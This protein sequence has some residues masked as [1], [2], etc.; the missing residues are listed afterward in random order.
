MAAAAR[1]SSLEFA[2]QA[3]LRPIAELAEGIGLQGD[4]GELCA[5]PAAFN[6]DINGRT[7]GLV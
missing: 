1:P 3:R 5:T 4:E 2:Q 7:V 6:V